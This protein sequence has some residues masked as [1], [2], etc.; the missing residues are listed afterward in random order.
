MA[1]NSKI[2]WT[3][4]TLNFIRARNLETG[5]DG[6]YCEKESPGCAGCYSERM[7]PRFKN[8]IRFNAADRDKAEIYLDEKVLT[9]PLRWQKPRL[10]FPCSMTDICGPWVK[11][12]WLDKFFAVAALT[13]QHTYQ[14][15]TKHPDRLRDYLARR[16]EEW[17]E[18]GISETAE[19]L[20]TNSDEVFKLSSVLGDLKPHLI[21]AGWA[22]EWDYQ[23]AKLVYE[24]GIPLPN[25]WIGTSVENQ[26]YADKRIPEL[27]KIP[28]AVR[29]LSIEPLLGP[30]KLT[31]IPTGHWAYGKVDVMSGYLCGDEPDAMYAYDRDP[32]GWTRNEPAY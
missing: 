29:F 31:R 28:A 9:Q 6:H 5:G 24:G 22:W 32:S 16:S 17:T 27:L 3:G 15:L 7:Q 30:V 2:E 21:K 12:E 20:L 25:V 26:K 13:P 19:T 10:I 4:S 11:D 18:M 1:E 23:D 14:V 8:N